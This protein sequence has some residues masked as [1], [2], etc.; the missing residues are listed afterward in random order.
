MN[1]HGLEILDCTLRDGGY[2]TNWDF[3]KNI[4]DSYMES[5]QKLP[6]DILELGYRSIQQKSYFGKY[7]YFPDIVVEQI[8]KQNHFKRLALMFNEKETTPK[9]LPKMLAGLEGKIDLIR[10]AVNPANFERAITLAEA[11]KTKGFNVSFNLMYMSNYYQD[12]VFFSKLEL[13]N[14]LVEYLNVVDSYG[15]MLPNQ[16][17][18]LVRN[19]K[20]SCTEKV[21]FH[22]HDNLELAFANT[23]A[24]IDAGCDIV[25]ATIL[26][27]GRGAGNLKTELLLTHL[28]SKGEVDFDFNLLSGLVETW[29]PLREEHQWGTNLPY[30]V[31]GANSLPQKDVMEWVTQRYYSFNSI[32]RALNN[33]KRGEQDN[34]RLPIFKPTD[35]YK[36]V[37]IIGGGP[38]AA[39]HADA[40]KVFVDKLDDACVVH[41]SSKNA[42]SY[43]DVKCKQFYCLV[44]NEGRRLESVFNDLNFFAGQ[45]ILPPFPRKMGTY[46]PDTI[47][48][49]SFELSEVNFTDKFM[50]AHT[51]LALQ[52]ALDLN[53]ESIYIVGYD[54]YNSQLITA[55]E[56]N[57]ISENEYIFKKAIEK[58]NI[59]SMTSTNYSLRTESVYSI[60]S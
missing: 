36:N 16:V 22:G 10:L 60:I 44:G 2:Y 46:L 53:A 1:K 50:D 59:V 3:S 27:M 58:V 41:A 57:L 17:K 14:G 35:S 32:I 29:T 54:G 9:D 45:C 51:S 55:K 37:I 13:I 18:E 25:D 31:S 40:I 47:K 52:T 7:F 26:G 8:A 15:G 39:N 56:R 12:N 5:M 23:L 33:Q 11:I 6:V 48:D 38:N 34:F 42:K 49:K 28:I 43:E 20:M 21:G 24:A 4:V 30:M 19:V